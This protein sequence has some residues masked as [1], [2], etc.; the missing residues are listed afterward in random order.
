MNMPPYRDGT[1]QSQ[2]VGVH[3]DQERM[4]VNVYLTLPFRENLQSQNKEK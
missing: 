2:A 4:M 3:F 1:S